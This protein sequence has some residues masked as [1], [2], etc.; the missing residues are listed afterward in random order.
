MSTY[1]ASADPVYFSMAN[2][3]A[4]NQP[5]IYV[6]VT[7][8]L[9]IT[10]VNNT[11]A[12][13][14]LQ[15][16]DSNSASGIEV[17]MP[18]FFTSDQKAV[19]TISNISQPGWGFSYDAPYKGLLLTYGN[20]S[21]TW[22]AGTNL[23]FTINLITATASPTI[24]AVKMNL[25]NLNG[26]NVPASPQPQNLALNSSAPPAAVDLTTVL[27]L[28]LDNQ[29]TVYVS[30]ATDPLSN[31]IF[32][33]IKNIGA[34]PLYNDSVPW[35]GNPT[36]TVSFVYGDTAGALAS[37]DDSGTAWSIGASVVT[38]QAWGY[39]NPT[40]TH[41]GTNPVW[42]LYPQQGN[43][44]IIGTGADAN[45]TFAFSNIN[46]FTPAG[47]TQMMVTFNNFMMNSTT[48]YKPATFILDIS[49][50]DA[51]LTR[52]LFGFFGVNGSIIKLTGPTQ[53]ISIPLKWS[54]FY[55]DN[56]KLFCSVPG[57]P[58]LERN[59]YKKDQTPNIQPLAYDTFSLTLPIQVAQDT[60]VFLTLQ[61]FDNN[62]NYLNSLQ[63]T[64]FISASF[65]VD[66]GGQVYPTVFLNNQT[67]LAANYNYGTGCI[68]YG[69][70]NGNRTTYGLLYSAAQAVANTPAGWRIPSQ[71]DW[72]N[73]ITSLGANAYAALI[74]G[75]SSGFN[76]QGGGMGDGQG[77]FNSM[78]ATGYYWTGTANNQ[79]P[80]SNF[81]ALFFLAQQKVNVS[82]SIAITN[83]LSVRYVKNT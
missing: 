18:S 28:G 34:N 71:A 56:I 50:Q 31:T 12:D 41:T 47:H 49:K 16:G 66:P 67:W 73:L 62:N 40:N 51:P 20:A 43:A 11:G 24:D 7:A 74:A 32:L 55:V 8:T 29:G 14:T 78:G 79:Q 69:N 59:Y 23:T 82:N 75:G 21:G 70:D 83:L 17:F 65:F 27:Q 1:T 58:Q 26:T 72:N 33:N 22:A 63:F 13:I 81:D 10:I 45:L 5:Q 48:A 52:G 44:G 37:D 80:G 25:Y 36:V 54:M 19:M 61:A 9:N 39:K 53:N 60:A 42:T 6:G 64:I 76:A 68:A 30:V 77:N 2:P 15:T 35:T 57:I 4:D 3:A 38:D 46:S